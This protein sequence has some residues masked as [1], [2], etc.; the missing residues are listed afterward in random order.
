M[1][2]VIGVDGINPISISIVSLAILPSTVCSVDIID[3]PLHR[4]LTYAAAAAFELAVC[5]KH[6]DKSD[7]SHAN[8]D[9]GEAKEDVE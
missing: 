8:R 1:I 9:A 5:P 7:D 6:V 3:V 4:V 2:V